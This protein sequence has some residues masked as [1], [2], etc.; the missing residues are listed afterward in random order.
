MALTPVP[1]GYALKRIQATLD[2]DTNRWSYVG[3]YK[4]TDEPGAAPIPISVTNVGPTDAAT[5]ELAQN[6]LTDAL[7]TL[8][9]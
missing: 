5:P 9:T 3:I 1:D 6:A 2:P 8:V 7:T 4:K